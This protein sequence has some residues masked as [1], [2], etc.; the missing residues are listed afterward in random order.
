[1]GRIQHLYL[2]RRPISYDDVRE[3]MSLRF[4]HDLGLGSLRAWV[5]RHELADQ[6]GSEDPGL[7]S[8]GNNPEERDCLLFSM[9]VNGIPTRMRDWKTVSGRR[10]S[11]TA[12]TLVSLAVIC[13]AE[14]ISLLS[15]R[16]HIAQRR[17]SSLQCPRVEATETPI[18]ERSQHAKSTLSSV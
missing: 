15:V 6:A 13:Y 10:R 4:G 18:L 11:P 9:V 8:D 14:Y 1:M 3:L 17:E 5:C 12:M 2:E 16:T 7:L